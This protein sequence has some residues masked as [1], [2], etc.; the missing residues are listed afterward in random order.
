MSLFYWVYSVLNDNIIM[1]LTNDYEL[2]WC[3]MQKSPEGVHNGLR[4]G[5][6]KVIIDIFGW[7]LHIGELQLIINVLNM[8]V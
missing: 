6:T 8:F 2:F 4:A 5:G 7:L 1:T 3:F